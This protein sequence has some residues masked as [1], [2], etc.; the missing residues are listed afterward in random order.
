VYTRL[1]FVEEGRLKNRIVSKTGVLEDDLIMG[2]LNPAF[3]SG[4]IL[5]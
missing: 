4:T 5:K 2:W 3:D 1:G